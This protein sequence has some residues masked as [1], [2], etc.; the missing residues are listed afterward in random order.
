MKLSELLSVAGKPL[1]RDKV[2]CSTFHSQTKRAIEIMNDPMIVDIDTNM[3]DKYVEV[4]ETLK[5]HKGKPL[6]GTTINRNV[7][8]IST[9]L[10]YARKRN[11][12][13]KLPYF[14]IKS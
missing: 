5:S 14:P 6:T 2:G 9:L 1:W 12:I 8:V 11:W 10:G 13:E 4:L 3:L 7:S